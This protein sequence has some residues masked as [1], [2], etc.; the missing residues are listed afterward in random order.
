MNASATMEKS[1]SDNG[2]D[3]ENNDKVFNQSCLTDFFKQPR[4]RGRP[5]KAN[6]AEIYRS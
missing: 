3:D 5:R 6:T 1:S 2:G 4:K